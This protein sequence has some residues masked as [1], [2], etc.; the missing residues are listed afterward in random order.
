M[1]LD[2]LQIHA[3]DIKEIIS[4]FIV[5][6]AMID[7][8]GLTPIAIDIQQKSGPINPGKAASYSL[9]VLLAFLFL[10][11]MVLDLFG[12][13]IHSFAVAGAIIIFIMGFEMTAGIEII[14]YSDGPKGS[15]TIVPIV[16]PLIAGA[17]TFTA[18]LS[19]RA[20]YHLLNIICALVLNIMVVYLVLKNMHILEKLLG[21]GGIY[22][23]KKFFGIILLAIAVK[24]FTS[25]LTALINL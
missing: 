21:P 24:L 11:N 10:G 14:K 19:L 12:V 15:S 1:S 2:I 13:D 18:L 22:I 23:L 6:F 17:G 3:L 4:A 7:V 25:N 20:E 16:F 8:T 5:I 9:I